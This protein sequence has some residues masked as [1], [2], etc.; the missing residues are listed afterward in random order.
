[1]LSTTAPAPS[2]PTPTVADP[3]HLLAAATTRTTDLS[4]SG[5]VT[6]GAITIL[7]LIGFGWLVFHMVKKDKLKISHLIAI[8]LT[9]IIAQLTPM[10]QLGFHAAMN[11]LNGLGNVGAGA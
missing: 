9:V 7:A 10:G 2:T 1:M 4:I 8:V 3:G 6:G 5:G 11:A